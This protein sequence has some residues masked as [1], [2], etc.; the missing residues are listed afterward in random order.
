MSVG[1]VA[2]V[3][4]AFV[5]VVVVVA[6]VQGEVVVFMSVRVV[7]VVTVALVVVAVVTVALVVVTTD[8]ES[9]GQRFGARKLAG[10]A[11]IDRVG[12]DEIG[13]QF[14]VGTFQFMQSRGLY[15]VPRAVHHCQ[16][17]LFDLLSEV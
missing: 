15:L 9:G 8:V 12:R 6:V 17:L 16:T 4:V 2:V 14:H 11:I 7:A 3:V 13:Q 10:L 5:V 1:V